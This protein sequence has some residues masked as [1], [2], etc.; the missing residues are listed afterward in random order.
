MGAFRATSI[1]YHNLG[2]ILKTPRAAL[3]LSVNFFANRGHDPFIVCTVYGQSRLA[4]MASDLLAAGIELQFSRNDEQGRRIV[5]VIERCRFGEHRQSSS[6]T[7]SN[8]LNSTL[9]LGPLRITDDD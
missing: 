4:S 7:V 8:P 6:V 9:S 5:S 3:R 2:S 1:A